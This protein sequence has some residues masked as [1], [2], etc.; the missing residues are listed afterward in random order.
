MQAAVTRLLHSE[1]SSD[2][3]RISFDVDG[4]EEEVGDVGGVCLFRLSSVSLV[5]IGMVEG[6]LGYDVFITTTQAVTQETMK[7]ILCVLKWRY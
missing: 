7:C 2:S 6:K 1:R 4:W 3:F 5:V